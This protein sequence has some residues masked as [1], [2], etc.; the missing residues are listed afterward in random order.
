MK[1]MWRM[2]AENFTV[3]QGDEPGK[4][5]ADKYEK[6]VTLRS[7]EGFEPGVSWNTDAID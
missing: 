1:I 5:V 6:I 4:V 3:T 7:A 2:N